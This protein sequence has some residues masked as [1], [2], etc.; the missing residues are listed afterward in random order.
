MPP[1]ERAAVGLLEEKLCPD[2]SK[3]LLPPVVGVGLGR[4][5][6]QYQSGARR[7]ER[8]S[9]TR[10]REGG[11]GMRDRVRTASLGSP[12][13]WEGLEPVFRYMPVG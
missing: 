9:G 11:P 3:A 13:G 5:E 7:I 1:A 6:A 12:W 2:A 8:V 4:A 10:F